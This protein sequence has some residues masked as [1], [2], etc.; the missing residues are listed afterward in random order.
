MAI[1]LENALLV[2]LEKQRPLL[3]GQQ[4]V[5]DQGAIAAIGARVDVGRF[6]IK[7]CIDCSG[8]IVMPGLVN[9][10]SHLTEILQ[11]SLR[12]NVR[13]EIWRGYRALT[14]EMADL[15]AEEIGAAAELACAEML[16]NGVTAVL[17]LFSTSPGLSVTKMQAILKA[18]EKTGIRG[19]LAP[20]LRDQ[21]F[22]QLISSRSRA[23]RATAQSSKGEWRDQVLALLSDMRRSSTI[24]GIV[25]GPSSPYNCSDALL[26]EIIEMAEKHDLGIHTHLLETRLQRWGSR[27]LYKEGLARHL[28]NLGFLSP[29]LSVAHGVWLEEKEMDLLAST[30]TSV[31]HNPASNLK[32]GS[33]IAPVIELNKRGVNVALGSDGGDTSDSYSI[34]EQMRLAAYLSRVRA[35]NSDHWITALDALRMGTCNGAQ[36]IL[37]WRGKIGRIK[38]GYRADLVILKPHLRLYPLNDVIHQLVF[39]EGG[40]SVDTVLVDGAIVVKGGRLTRLDEDRVIQRAQDIGAKMCHNYSLAKRRSAQADTALRGLYQRAFRSERKMPKE[41]LNN[42]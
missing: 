36:A 26:R 23:R 38:T 11:R 8:M 31:V 16:K 10:H 14:E 37:P 24:S 19:V 13:M 3:R 17:D 27:K 32:L 6:E 1:L 35:E 28:K 25:L 41:F 39:C 7:E 18:F 2:T 9:A 22:V 40:Q 12:D 5:V 34:F 15:K 29:R 30:A 33:G 20:S 42:G 21:D 4:L